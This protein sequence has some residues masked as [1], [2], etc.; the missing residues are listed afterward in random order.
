MAAPR[1]LE[2]DLGV[3]EPKLARVLGGIADACAESA[4]ALRGDAAHAGATAEQNS[5]GVRAARRVLC[6]GEARGRRRC[7]AARAPSV[8]AGGA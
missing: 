2:D 1:T 6:G 7:G 3:L 5:F 4:A 8:V